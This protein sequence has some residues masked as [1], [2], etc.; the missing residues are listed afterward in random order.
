MPVY[1]YNIKGKTLDYYSF[2][3]NQ[4]RA[5]LGLHHPTC[6][7]CLKKGS[8]YLNFFKISDKLI[9]G[10]KSANLSVP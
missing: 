8:S 6:T 1:L 3:L 5:D 10:A 2:S 9:E 7:K 4:I